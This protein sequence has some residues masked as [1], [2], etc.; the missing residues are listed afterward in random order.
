MK[1]GGSDGGGLKL[2]PIAHIGELAAA[3]GPVSEGR[4]L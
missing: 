2:R 4:R 3:I 1:K